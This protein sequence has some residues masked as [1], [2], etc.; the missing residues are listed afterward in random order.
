VRAGTEL[1]DKAGHTMHEVVTSIKRVTGII[2]AI[3]DASAEQSAGIEQVLG[4]SHPGTAPAIHLVSNNPHRVAR[5][6]AR[7]RAKVSGVREVALRP[8]APAKPK[9]ARGSAASAGLDWK[10]F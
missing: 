5:P 4:R 9:R 3:A 1:A 8:A 6:E 7:A 10:E 2:G